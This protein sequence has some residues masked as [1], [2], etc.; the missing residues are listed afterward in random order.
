MRQRVRANPAGDDAEVLRE[1]DGSVLEN[2][3]GQQKKCAENEIPGSHG[4]RVVAR[5]DTFTEDDV[6]GEA[7]RT[8]HGDGVGE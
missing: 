3:D 6:H 5:G 1:A 7:E 4:E 8:A 2:S